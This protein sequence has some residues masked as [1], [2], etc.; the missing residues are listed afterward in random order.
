M[1]TSY[2]PPFY[3]TPP[4]A[5]EK[6]T[7]ELKSAVQGTDHAVLEAAVSAGR[8]ATIDRKLIEQGEKRL[9]QLVGLSF[10]SCSLPSFTLVL[11]A[12]P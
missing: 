6:A 8:Q 7:K 4:K 9:A 12:R 5:A 1:T 10:A 2:P 3:C 11:S